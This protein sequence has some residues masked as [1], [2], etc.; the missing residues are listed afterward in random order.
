MSNKQKIS[1]D[2]NAD[3][4][5]G[6]LGDIDTFLAR[7]GLRLSSEHE[8]K[9]QGNLNKVYFVENDQ[10]KK[11]VLRIE[12]DDN[13]LDIETYIRKQ[14]KFLGAEDLG[15]KLVYRDMAEQARFMHHL[16]SRQI[17]TPV[18]EKYGSGWMLIHFSDGDSL[19]D[20][21]AQSSPEDSAPYVVAVLNEF[22]NVHKKG[23][24][25]WDRWG[26]NE[27]VDR[28]KN[29]CFLDF[30][31]NIVFPS[32]VP[33]KVQAGLDLAF[34]LRGCIQFSKDAEGMERTISNV[35]SS[36][37]D[38]TDIYDSKSLVRFLDGQISFYEAE[39]SKNASVPQDIREKHAAMNRSISAVRN[40][41]AKT[42]ER[43]GRSSVYKKGNKPEPL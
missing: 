30:D 21:L 28:Q 26:G 16:S 14:I 36:R 4:E 22:M 40:A 25:L 23:E 18:I 34:M 2:F 42:A 33:V 13:R 5:K 41:I 10:G 37:Q 32:N 19:K 7:E 27:L 20:I 39:Y 24:C 1:A 15:A 3:R 29:V 38:L 43:A 8:E 12:R 6:S 35:L 31:I 9:E 11:Y 17:S